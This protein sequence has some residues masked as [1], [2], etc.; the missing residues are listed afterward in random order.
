MKLLKDTVKNLNK[1]YQKKN[2]LRGIKYLLEVQKGDKMLRHLN[3]SIGQNLKAL[4]RLASKN[5]EALGQILLD[6][7]TC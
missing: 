3:L 2:Y 6:A 4:S 1:S 5:G 7:L